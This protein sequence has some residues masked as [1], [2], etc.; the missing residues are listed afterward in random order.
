[1]YKLALSVRRGEPGTEIRDEWLWGS[2]TETVWEFRSDR[3]LPGTRAL[4]PLLQL[5]YAPP[6]DLCGTV[7]AGHPHRLPVTVRQQPGLPAP[8][9]ARITV[10]VSFDEGLSWRA[11]RINGTGREVVATIAAGGAPGGTVSLRVRA[12]DTAGNAIEQTVLRAY[13]LR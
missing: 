7:S 12:R 10:D 9:G 6:T 2:A 1:M 3:P 4:L 5:D 13:G 8:R 11:A